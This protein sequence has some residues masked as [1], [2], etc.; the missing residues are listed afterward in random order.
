M[1]VHRLTEPLEARHDHGAFPGRERHE[2]RADAGVSH[3]DAALPDEVDELLVGHVGDVPRS[4]GPNGRRPVLDHGALLEARE[5]D[6]VEQTVEARLVRPD[7]DDD[8]PPSVNTLPTYRACFTSR[9]ASGHC[10]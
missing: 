5:R 4:F 7:A 2:D 6:P 10:T 9:S 8:H 1:I 3:E